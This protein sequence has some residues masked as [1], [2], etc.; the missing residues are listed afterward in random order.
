VELGESCEDKGR[1][2]RGNWEEHRERKLRAGY[3]I[4]K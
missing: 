4:N 1:E 2:G 3:K